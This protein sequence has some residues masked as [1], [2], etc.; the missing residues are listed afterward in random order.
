[1]AF[2]LCLLIIIIIYLL[3]NQYINIIYLNCRKYEFDEKK[4]IAGIDTTFAVVKRKTEK[5]QACKYELDGNKI[6]ADG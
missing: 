3:K 5:N 4:I 6:I 1:M 2:S